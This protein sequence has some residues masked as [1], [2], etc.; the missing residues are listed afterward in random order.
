MD[1][2]HSQE[3][4]DTRCAQCGTDLPD[5][6]PG[7]PNPLAWAKGATPRFDS[8]WQDGFCS[9][10]CFLA[11]GEDRSSALPMPVVRGL[12]RR[13]PDLTVQGFCEYIGCGS[14]L[15]E[16]LRRIDRHNLEHVWVVLADGR[17][18]YYHHE[19]D[20]SPVLP[21]ARVVRVGAG[22]IAWDGSDWEF[23]CDDPVGAPTSTGWEPRNA[24]AVVDGVR[25]ACHDAYSE[26]TAERDAEDE[27]WDTLAVG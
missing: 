15:R 3:G 4:D 8:V 2:F 16:N 10:R 20:D 21:T 14:T 9:C 26:Y 1:Y 27:D 22:C 19:W 13:E 18:I 7:V 24:W 12:A 11:R 25:S 6:D 23:S 5:E 17:T